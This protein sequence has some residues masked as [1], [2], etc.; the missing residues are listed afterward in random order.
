MFIKKLC[1]LLLMA[2]YSVAIQTDIKRGNLNSIL[3]RDEWTKLAM[4]YIKNHKPYIVKKYEPYKPGKYNLTLPSFGQEWQTTTIQAVIEPTIE[5]E[6]STSHFTEEI[7]TT[8]SNIFDLDGTTEET[9][10][11]TTTSEP[12]FTIM[13]ADTTEQS[14]TST[15][16][17]ESTTGM[18]ETTTS[19]SIV[20]WETT[21]IID[22]TTT[23]SFREE[24]TGEVSETTTE[25]SLVTTEWPATTTGS[26]ETSETTTEPSLNTTESPETSTSVLEII[27]TTSGIETTTYLDNLIY[28][29]QPDDFTDLVNS[30]TTENTNIEIETST[31]VSEETT[32]EAIRTTTPRSADLVEDFVKPKP[33]NFRYS[34]DT[35]PEPYWL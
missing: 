4:E 29:P 33:T 13:E 30:T 22:T 28:I 16:I 25:E 26:W 11:Q 14:P 10:V 5:P 15:E 3:D 17:P 23:V 12:Q 6:S 34:S 32:T 24:S 21:P 2:H 35:R 19:W 8:T 27:S 1:F 9:T 18:V 7:S 31:I 20:D